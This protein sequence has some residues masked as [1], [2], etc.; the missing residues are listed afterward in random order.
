MREVFCSLIGSAMFLSAVSPALAGPPLVCHTIKIEGAKSLPFGTGA[1]DADSGYDRAR[2]ADDVLA[3]LNA[4]TPVLVR[5]ETL[6]RATVYA[7]KN[8][9]VA[10]RLAQSLAGRASK[11]KGTPAEALR[12]FD[13]SYLA[14]CLHQYGVAADWSGIPEG[15]TADEGYAGVQEA[16]SLSHGDPAMEFAAALMARSPVRPGFAEHLRLARAGAP[17]GSLLARNLA[18]HPVLRR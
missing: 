14:G 8:E 16:I 3:L 6:R 18:E 1:F 11:E 17:E 10:T 9:A 2:M 5:M 13:V 12:V 15:W 7:K 4:G